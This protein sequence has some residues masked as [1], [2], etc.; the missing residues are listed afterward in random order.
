MP[1]T[2]RFFYFGY[3]CPHNTYLLARVKT[4]AWKEAAALHLYDVTEDEATCREYG[5]L[6][7]TTLIVNDE[8]RWYGPFSKELLVALLEDEEIPMPEQAVDILGRPVQ[9]DLVPVTEESVLSTCVPCLGCDD[10]GMCRG[11]AEWVGSVLRRTGEENLG[12]L[13]FVDGRCVGGAEYVPSTL[14]PYPIPGRDARTAFLTCSFGSRAEKDFR[15]HPLSRLEEHLGEIGYDN[16]MMV[17]SSTTAFPNGTSSW[18]E[19]RGYENRG[20]LSTD[21]RTGDELHLLCKPV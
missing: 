3:Q 9:G 12:Y 20:S 18:F 4:V 7:P 5:I 13:H 15:S 2:I 8:H 1:R 6:T 19:E 17:A 14:V 11:K 21:S 16:L 10:V